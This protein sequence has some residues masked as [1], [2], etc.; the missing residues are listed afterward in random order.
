MLNPK[1]SKLC[2][3]TLTLS[4]LQKNLPVR[5]GA[6]LLK[7]AYETGINFFDTAELYRNYEYIKQ[8]FLPGDG[9]TIAAKTY[10]Y[11]KEGAEKS[12]DKYLSETGR[13][14][15]EIF[16][17]HEQESEH[18]LRGHGEAL[19]YLVRKKE[20]GIIGAVGI[21]TH[22]VHAVTAA[23][24]Y[25]QI[26]VIH[27]ILNLRGIGIADGTRQDMEHVLKKAHEHG[28][29]IYAMKPLGGGHLINERY[30]ALEYIKNLDFI[31]SVAIGIGD[32]N[33]LEFNYNFWGSLPISPETETLTGISRRGIMIQNWCES[34]GEC[35]KV[36]KPG[37]LCI[38]ENKLACD[39]QKCILCGYCGAVCKNMAIKIV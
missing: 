29:F 5:E 18:T 9:C 35:V 38:K 13:E 17:L 6:Y 16:L 37:A 27:P 30:A 10:A 21:S 1:I 15:A 25:P 31:D 39:K 23:L 12:L 19:E 36:C 7:R 34:C 8:A 22:C 20:E 24:K 26:E 11:N 2:F 3:G 28:K 14:R 4:P 32:E 33:E